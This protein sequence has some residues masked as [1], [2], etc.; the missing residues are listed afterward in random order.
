MKVSKEV[1]IIDVLI[2]FIAVVSFV[3]VALLTLGIFSTLLSL[4]ISLV[5][6]GVL[7]LLFKIKIVFKNKSLTWWLIPILLISLFLRLSPNLYLT[8][9]QDQGTYVSLSKQ[10]QE[11]N[12][13]Y[14]TDELRESLSDDAKVLYDKSN[15]VLGVDLKDE[16]TSEY[17]MPFYPVLPS[18]MAMFGDIFG[19]DNRVYAMTLFGLLSILGIYLFSYEISNKNKKVGLL[20]AFLLGINPLHVYFSRIPLTEIVSLCLLLFSLYYLL[21]FYNRYKEGERNI[22][23]LPLSLILINALFYTRMTGLFY[24][25]VIFLIALVTFVYIKEQDFRKSILRYVSL[26]LFLFITS[27]AFYYFYLPDLFEL[28]IG[29]R[30]PVNIVVIG[31]FIVL[32]IIALVIFAKE[33]VTNVIKKIL[34]WLAKNWMYILL[35]IFIILIGYQVYGYVKEIFIDNQYALTSYESLSYLKQLSFLATVLYLSPIVFLCIPISLIYYRKNKDIKLLMLFL[36][37]G[38]F[39]IYSWGVLKLAPYHYYYVRY[40]VSEL[41]PFCLVLIS[42]LLVD[43]SKSKLGKWFGILTVLFTTVYMGFFS[44]IQLREFEGADTQTYLELQEL[45][46]EDDLLFVAKNELKAFSQVTLPLKYYY[47][48]NVFPLHSISYLD[49]DPIRVLKKEY[50]NIYVLYK[51]RIVKESRLKYVGIVEF[52]NNYFVHC[53]RD[54]D[55][56][57]EMVGHSEDLPYCKYMIIPNRYYNGSTS[58]YLY[59]LE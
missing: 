3:N 49:K 2:T 37:I 16:E 18:W 56:Y 22:I 48:V 15:I 51:I 57:F 10:Y 44:L 20:A 39:L 47:D 19:S 50:E 36:F 46:G 12:S 23:S 6:F 4:V 21:K 7:K 54:E 59:R 33:K 26:W 14:F 5:V 58:M 17:V 45:V 52:K 42:V 40:Q 1:H 24:I 31:I 53:L 41:I 29:K 38:I 32:L 35:A 28:I 34:A 43:I 13:L 8:G 55:R 9:G 30:L 25:P 27:Y 11:S